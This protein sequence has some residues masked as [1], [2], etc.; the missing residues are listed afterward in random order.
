MGTKIPIKRWGNANSK[1]VRTEEDAVSVL[2]RSIERLL[3]EGQ[4]E[5]ER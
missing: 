5:E 2:R 4:G 3:L 1:N